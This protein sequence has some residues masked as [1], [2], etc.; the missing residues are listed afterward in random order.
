MMLAETH[1]TSK[2]NFQIRG[3]T[4]YCAGHPGGNALKTLPPDAC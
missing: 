2:F 4:A 1:L 3:C